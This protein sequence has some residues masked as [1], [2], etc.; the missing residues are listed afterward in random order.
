MRIVSLSH[1]M[2]LLVLAIVSCSKD[3]ATDNIDTTQWTTKKVAVVLPMRNGQ[4]T[5]WKRTLNQCSEDLEK[6]FSG[7]KTGIRLEY[8]WY[9]ESTEDIGELSEKLAQ[10][11]DIV[12]VIGGMYSDNAKTMASKFCRSVVKKPF[13]TTATTEELIRGYSSARCLWAMTETDI[14]QC[15]TLLSLAYSYGGKSVALIANGNSMYGKTFVDWFGFQAEELGMKTV[16]VYDYGGSSIEEAAASAAESGADFV[17][18][19]PSAVED[20]R[21]IEESMYRQSCMGNPLPPRCL[22]S[23]VAFGTEVI[24]MLG[25]LAEGLEGV[26]VGSDP[27][28]GFDVR[29]ETTYNETP[30]G[31]ESQIYDAAMMIGY[32]SF[33]QHDRN[34]LSL[35]EAIKTLVDGRDD[36]IYSPTLE[37]MRDYV[38]ALSVGKAP[39][40]RGVSGQLDFDKD[41][42]TN[43]LSS[44]YYTYQVYGGKYIIL[45]YIS[46][47]GSAHTSSSLANWQWKSSRMQDFEDVDSSGLT[48]PDLDEKWALLV[49]G[50]SGWT[51][52]RHQ[53][54]VLYMYQFL[55][56]NGYDDDHI[57]LIA[58]DD[59]ANNAK[60][61]TPGYMSVRVGG[62]N[63][64]NDVQIDYHTS[65]ITPADIKSILC[66][67]RDSRLTQVIGADEDD[68]VFI[69]WSGH[70]S[71][72]Q[73]QWLEE[74]KGFT[75]ELAEETFSTMYEK[76][77]YRKVLC[78][79][80]TC[81]SGSVFTAIEGLPGMLA[82]T[83]ANANES[84]KADV[85]N[86]D[87]DVW[88][89]NRFTMT[90]QDCVS[91]NPRISLRDLYYKL[92]V[93][94]VGS[95]VVLFNANNYGNIYK[96]NIGE[97]L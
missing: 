44:T 10:R 29:Y 80:E 33:I 32:A 75:R 14:S 38:S 94:T 22:Y 85:Y 63:V 66:G 52:Y 35:N 56:Q 76:K 18:C 96:N 46:N 90:F 43:V 19:A 81:Y 74:R 59:I 4:D 23:D 77:C 71:K 50:S 88:M 68:N 95:H 37:G 84:S 70:G 86:C 89:S 3:N 13:F 72:G 39:N 79:V 82:F 28:T 5:H 78:M 6:A 60:N 25:E 58:E 83:A 21:V 69:F 11:K 67:E 2:I 42:Y 41:V 27:S 47:N 93:N 62:D 17:I 55:R 40:L 30:L 61:P 54:D 64:Y 92:F 87:L 16:G 53:A 8:E 57:V 9:D 31:G 51:N 12:A 34:M 65:D 15:E 73:L 91:N 26:A 20:I 49:A 24:D 7:Q 36:F 48:Y 97:F 1:V 45:D